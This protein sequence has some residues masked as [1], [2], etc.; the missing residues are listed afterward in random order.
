MAGKIKKSL[1]EKKK[2]SVNI[3]AKVSPFQTSGD[4]SKQSWLLC[5]IFCTFVTCTTPFPT[6]WETAILLCQVTYMWPPS[7][8]NY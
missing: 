3:E 7:P 4:S 5:H 2:K 8:I 6:N 1:W